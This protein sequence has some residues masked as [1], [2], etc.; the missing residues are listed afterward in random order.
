MNFKNVV[1]THNR[2]LLGH[3]EEV[4]HIIYRK[5]D[6]TSDRRMDVTRD[7]HAKRNQTERKVPQFPPIFSLC[8]K[9]ERWSRNRTTGKMIP[10]RRVGKKM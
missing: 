1:Y 10:G 9:K 5:I 8:I 2:A 7:Y 6:V 4:N 3:K